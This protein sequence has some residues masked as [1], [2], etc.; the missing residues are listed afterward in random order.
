MMKNLRNCKGAVAAIVLV[1]LVSGCSHNDSQDTASAKPVAY[2]A[3]IQSNSNIPAQARAALMQ[4]MQSKH[5]AYSQQL[6]K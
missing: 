4:N 5:T 2:T 6:S 3:N 1:S